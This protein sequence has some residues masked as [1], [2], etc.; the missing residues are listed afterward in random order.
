[1]CIIFD[2]YELKNHDGNESKMMTE[3]LMKLRPLV[4]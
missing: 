1:M 2:V 4:Y 3:M